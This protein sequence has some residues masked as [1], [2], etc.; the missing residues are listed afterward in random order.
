[1]T[2]MARWRRRADR[3]LYRSLFGAYRTLFPSRPWEGPIPPA[4]LRRVLV[5][6]H[7]RMGDAVVTTP[8]IGLLHAALPHAEL[9]V[10][11]SPANRAVF[12]GDPRISRVYVN[13][14]VSRT[15][16]RLARA[17]RARRY[18][19]IFSVIH[20]RGL[21]EGLLA[22]LFSTRDTWR[23]SVDR[24]T[25]YAGL[26]SVTI[27]PPRTREHVAEQLL[28]VG[29]RAIDLPAELLPA[30]ATRYPMSLPVDEAAE[31]RVTAMLERL[32]LSRFS[33]VNLW[34]A[35]PWRAW[36]V[37][38][39]AGVVRQLRERGVSL[40]FLL[41][42]PPGREVEAAVAASACGDDAR[43]APPSADLRDLI[44]LVR[45]AEL[46]LTP[47]TGV[48][49]LASACR[50]PVVAL[51]STRTVDIRRWLPLGV[52][53]RAV[54]ARR[55]L[56]VSAIEETQVADAIESLLRELGR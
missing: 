41:V 54:V 27:R 42:P 33:L 8:L 24:P 39:V 31:A 3:R 55:G 11:A 49:H 16:P 26:F 17:L 38:H 34:A 30:D 9:D 50:R 36:P 32:R 4:A 29:A 2:T 51:Y 7:D 21:R 22:S 18:D 12:D 6:R 23:I 48:V 20:G 19:A 13:D 45:R 56:P 5:V 1:M 35:E 25:R 40:P 15:L 14:H 10:V 52:P 47:D 53:H 28:V 37:A 44:A 46:V 43:V